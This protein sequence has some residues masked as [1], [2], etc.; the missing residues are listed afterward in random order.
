VQQNAR[1]QTDR[2]EPLSVHRRGRRAGR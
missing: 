1:A 2:G